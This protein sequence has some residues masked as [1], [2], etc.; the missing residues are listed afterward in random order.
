VKRIEKE[1][2]LWSVCI[3]IGSMD[4]FTT[5]IGIREGFVEK[6]PIGKYS[7]ESFGF[8]SLIIIKFSI[9]VF[10]LVI[11][12]YLL[13]DKWRYMPPILLSIV[14]I[15]AVLINLVNIL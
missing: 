4:L 9:I 2:V 12:E 8:P 6:N 3:F 1:S 14:W 11:T 5:W 13:M 7:I 10:I 15:I